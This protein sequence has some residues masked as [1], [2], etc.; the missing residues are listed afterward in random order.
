MTGEPNRGQNERLTNPPGPLET[1]TNCFKMFLPRMAMM[2]AALRFPPTKS[3]NAIGGIGV[4]GKD[5]LAG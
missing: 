2:P 4:P 5:K 1:S 3:V